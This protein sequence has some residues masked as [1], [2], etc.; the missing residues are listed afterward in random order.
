MNLR[1][2]QRAAARLL[3]DFR[4]TDRWR[5]EW[6]RAA[7]KVMD[8]VKSIKRTNWGWASHIARQNDN[9]W[10]TRPSN[11]YARDRRRGRGTPQ[12]TWETYIDSISISRFIFEGT[13]WTRNTII[14]EVVERPTSTSSCGSIRLE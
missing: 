14:G 7:T 8:I 13:T 11:L 12:V 4:R 5:N 9:R 10:T 1:F 3:L 2:L 6:I